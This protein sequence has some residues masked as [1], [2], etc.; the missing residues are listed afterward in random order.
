MNVLIYHI[1]MITDI[2][3][4]IF[5]HSSFL[6]FF[7]GKPVPSYRM[8]MFLFFIDHDWNSY[9]VIIIVSTIHSAIPSIKRRKDSIYATKS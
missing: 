2:F 5:L 3:S 8:Y 4:I 1:D 6:S 9:A 7:F